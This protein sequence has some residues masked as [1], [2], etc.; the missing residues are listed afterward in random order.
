MEFQLKRRLEKL[1]EPLGFNLSFPIREWCEEH[2]S[3]K[4]STVEEYLPDLIK[5]LKENRDKLQLPKEIHVISLKRYVD[6]L[7]EWN[8]GLQKQELGKLP[9]EMLEMYVVDST[10]SGNIS[11]CP[12]TGTQT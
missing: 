3:L 12:E 10:S 8:Q 1:A 5:Y 11:L 4:C 6:A 9:R 7:I 2:V